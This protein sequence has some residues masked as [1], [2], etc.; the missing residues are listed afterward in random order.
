MLLL[1]LLQLLLKLLFRRDGW[2][3][4]SL[5]ERVLNVLQNSEMIKT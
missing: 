1:L 4:G 2:G 3:A 5:R